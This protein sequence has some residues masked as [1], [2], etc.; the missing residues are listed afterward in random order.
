MSSLA[1]TQAPRVL[2]LSE[3]VRGVRDQFVNWH[4]IAPLALLVLPSR[5]PPRNGL[6][7][8]RKT[9]F[10]LRS[11]TGFQA[12]CRL[13]EFNAFVEVFVLR[14]YDFA[15]IHWRGIQ[16]VFDIG[17]NI[18]A[19]TLWI[20]EK[21]PQATIIAVEPFSPAVSLL[22]YNISINGLDDRVSVLAAALGPS[23]GFAEMH[24]PGPTVLA[25]ATPVTTGK[26]VEAVPVVTLDELLD[27]HGLS[28]LDLLKL[29]C[30]GSEYDVLLSSDPRVLG[31]IKAIV[32]EYHKVEGRS[33][34]DLGNH[35]AQC[36]FRSV[37]CGEAARGVFCAVREPLVP[38]GAESPL[39]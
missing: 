2:T 38:S 1:L 37:F 28:E 33:P 27:R 24:T 32:G 17:A 19:A 30:E 15:Q 13:A 21:A 6:P 8:F 31:R 10:L 22:D 29:D 9:E 34:L 18:G 23:S 35:L 14:Q 25:R 12:R 11:R 26:S 16:T 39:T 5:C 3:L 7:L 20:A 36:D 4:L